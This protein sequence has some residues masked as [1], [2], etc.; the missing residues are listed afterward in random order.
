MCGIAGIVASS[1]I[2]RGPL[3]KMVAALRH[4][5]PDGSGTWYE[6]CVALGHTR[7]AIIERTELGAQPMHYLDR[8]VITFNG[9]IYNHREIRKELRASGYQFASASDTEVIMAAY[10]RWGVECLQ[11]FNGMWAFVLYDRRERILFVARDRF[12]VKPLYLASVA[13][14]CLFASEI[15]ALLLH[16]GMRRDPDL[17]YCQRYL[18][19]GPKEYVGPTAWAGVHRLENAHYLHGS[20]EQFVGGHLQA[21]RYWELKP[22]YLQANIASC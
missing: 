9:E 8:Y 7:L 16:Q 2:E 1:H 6:G 3:E 22:D 20:P 19:Y 12:G 18:V 21:K 14:A 5:G 15:K 4:R 11:R 17:D 10:D 13:G